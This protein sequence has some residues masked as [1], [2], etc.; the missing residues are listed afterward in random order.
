MNVNMCNKLHRSVLFFCFD[1]INARCLVEVCLV[2][3]GCLGLL[4]CKQL[5]LHLNVLRTP[6]SDAKLL[7]VLSLAKPL[8]KLRGHCLLDQLLLFVDFPADVGAP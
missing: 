6:A 8:D 5:V 7:H 2:G 1:S 4:D 3:H